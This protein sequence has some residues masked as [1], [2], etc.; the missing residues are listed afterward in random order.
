MFLGRVNELSKLKEE[1][2]KKQKSAVLVYGKHGM[3]K[4]TL[5]REASKGYNGTV[6]YHLFT[7]TTYEGNLAILCRSIALSLGL[8]EIRFN[9]VFVM[10]DYLGSTKR[11]IL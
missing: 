7:K 4:S 6:I 2:G 3:G 11:E 8:P 10:F 9:T 1:F 5:L